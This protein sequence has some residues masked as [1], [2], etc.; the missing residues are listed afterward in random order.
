[1]IPNILIYLNLYL[2]IYLFVCHVLAMSF[3]H[4]HCVWLPAIIFM[5]P[6]S[7]KTTPNHKQNVSYENCSHFWDFFDFLWIS[8]NVEEYH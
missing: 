4:R 5:T 6:K 1:M 2:F 7:I 3:G 8:K